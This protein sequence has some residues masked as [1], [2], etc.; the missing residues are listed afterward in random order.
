[1]KII[2][3]DS[4]SPH[5]CSLL[6]AALRTNT[7]SRVVVP[8]VRICFCTFPSLATCNKHATTVA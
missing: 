5:G 8:K 2:F 3:R 6:T 7:N 4:S 1:M